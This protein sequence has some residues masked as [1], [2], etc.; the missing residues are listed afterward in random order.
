MEEEYP[1]KISKSNKILDKKKLTKYAW[2]FAVGDGCLRTPNDRDRPN[3]SVNAFFECGQ[4]SDHEDY[5]LWRADILSNITSVYIKFKPSKFETQKSQL[6]TQTGRHPFFT[7]L[8]KRMYLEGHKVIDPHDLK[9]LDWESL[10]IIYQDDGCLSKKPKGN[11]CYT[12]TISTCSFSYGE[13]VMLQRA[14]K[15]KT[16]VLFGIGSINSVGG[17]KYRLITNK[18]EN[19]KKFTDGV[20]PFIKPSFEYKL[21]PNVQYPLYSRVDSDIV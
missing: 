15:D 16:D 13:Q 5:I 4:T 19:I 7:T 18:Y 1:L 9:L 11:N 21:L 14:I 2:A 12:L 17:I 3:N 20:K 8:K 6:H 10:A